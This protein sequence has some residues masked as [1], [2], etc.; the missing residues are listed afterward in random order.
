ML[1]FDDL[2]RHMRAYLSIPRVRQISY[3][4]TPDAGNHDK[5]MVVHIE[6]YG[7]TRSYTYVLIFFKSSSIIFFKIKDQCSIL[8]DHMSLY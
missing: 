8:N 6:R 4:V 7:S 2:F 1:L 5:Y 3:S